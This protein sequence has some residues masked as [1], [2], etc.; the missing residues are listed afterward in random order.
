MLGDREDVLVAAAAEIH[1]DD[2]VLANGRGELD[3]L[4]QRMRR[5][6]RRNDAFDP[7]AELE[8]VEGL[9]VGCRH[10]GDAAAITKPGVL[11]ADAGIVEAGGDRMTFEDLAVAVLQEV[12]PV[13]MQHARPPAIHRR[14]VAV[15]DL[16]AVTAGFDAVNPDLAIVEEGME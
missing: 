5:L 6:E 1:D 8:G 3:H 14:G 4:G 10:V 16:E 12:C 2:L 9:L 13:A 11:G 15:F 7:R